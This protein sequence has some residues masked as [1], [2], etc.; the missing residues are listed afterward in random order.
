[1]PR[2]LSRLQRFFKRWMSAE[3][4]ARHEAQSR[5]WIVTCPNCG[6]R[7]SIWDIGGMRGGASGKPATRMRCPSCGTRG[8]H[9]VRYE[10]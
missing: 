5:K 1:M 4:F 3:S 9:T 6:H 2:E 7:Q 8:W 10:P